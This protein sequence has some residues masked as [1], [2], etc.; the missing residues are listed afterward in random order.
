MLPQLCCRSQLWLRFNPRPGNS[1]CHGCSHKIKINKFLKDHPMPTS[2]LNSVPQCGH[3]IVCLANHPLMLSRLFFSFFSFSFF[4]F[5]FF[6]LPYFLSSFPSS[7]LPS[8]FLSGI[9]RAAPAAY[10]SSQAR[11]RIRTTAAGL[12]HSHSNTGSE[13]HL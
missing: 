10:G 3:T 11:S 12:H 13:L 2:Y 1:I 6:F 7:F 8:F 9:F 5:F 4:F